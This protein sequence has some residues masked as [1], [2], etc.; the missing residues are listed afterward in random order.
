M[1]KKVILGEEITII[2]RNK[3]GILA[4]IAMTLANKGIN[5]EA[6]LGYEVGISGK[7]FLVT[8]A[9]LAIISELKKKKYKMVKETEVILVDL[10]NK[11]GTLKVVA[12]EMKENNIDIKYIYVT[13]CTCANKGSSRMVLQTSD[14]EKAMALLNKYVGE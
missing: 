8:N 6:V 14:N 3:V 10:E 13:P 7:V 2:T 12:T 9:N 5:I 4:D 11:P 1:I